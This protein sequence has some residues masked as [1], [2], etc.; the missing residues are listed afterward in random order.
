MALA[1]RLN[2]LA[3]ANLEGLLRYTIALCAH[4][5]VFCA[6]LLVSSDDEYRLLR[7]NVFEQYSGNMVIP[8]EAPIVPTSRVRVQLRGGEP[9]LCLHPFIH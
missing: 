3:T 8:V 1:E 9:L 4:C 5:P 7:Q 6:H 2:E